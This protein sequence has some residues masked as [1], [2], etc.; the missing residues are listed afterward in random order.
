MR[1]PTLPPAT[2]TNVYV[3]GDG[4]SGL[5][6]IDPASP[7]PEE[8]AALDGYLAGLAGRV[9]A[10]LLTHHHVDHVSGAQHVSDRLGVPI[11]AHPRTA[12]LLA[13]RI[14][15]DRTL[16]EGDQVPGLDGL[17]V[18]HTPGHAEG[19]VCLLEESTAML[20]AGDMVASIGTIVIDPAPGEG[21]MRIYLEQLA[22]LRALRPSLL[23]PSHGE[24]VTDP[25]GLLAFYI[26]HRLEREGRV[27]AALAQGAGPVEQLVPL[28]Y[29]DVPPAIHPL[30]ARSLLSH[31]LKLQSEGRAVDEGGTWSLVRA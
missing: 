18:L 13:G 21:D 31:L 5:V 4:E 6:V 9:I 30:A 27:V 23:L 22:R 24:P 17:R 1:T 26:K 29:A 10:V 3:A 2:H 11:L 19:H 16:V 20:V 15:V 14:R 8:Q 28:A 25:D 7:Y 12:E